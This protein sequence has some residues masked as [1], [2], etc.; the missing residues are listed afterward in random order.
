M[1]VTNKLYANSSTEIDLFYTRD[2]LLM[3]QKSK[4]REREN[5]IVNFILRDTVQEL[6]C[7]VYQKNIIQ[8]FTCDT[9]SNI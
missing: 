3:I 2:V 5:D 6:K 1:S 8:Y 9:I 7:D 4:E